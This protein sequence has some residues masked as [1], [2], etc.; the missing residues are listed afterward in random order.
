MPATL[1]PLD[2]NDLQYRVE[3]WSTDGERRERVVL[4]CTQPLIAYAAIEAVRAAY[5]RNRVIVRQR[6]RVLRDVAPDAA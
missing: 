3:L 6:S 2:G 1:F 4:A 5:P